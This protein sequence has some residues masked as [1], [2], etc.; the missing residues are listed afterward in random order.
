MIL[1]MDSPDDTAP[2][3]QYALPAP[4]SPTKTR[5]LAADEIGVQVTHSPHSSPSLTYPSRSSM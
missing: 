3:L 5:S 1:T 4:A 2:V